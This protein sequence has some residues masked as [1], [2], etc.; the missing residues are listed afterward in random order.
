MTIE[1]R[2]DLE[3]GKYT[4]VLRSDGAM[5]ALRHDEPWRDLVGD[6]LVMAMAHEIMELRQVV[7]ADGSVLQRADA[8]GAVWE[9]LQ[10]SGA[11][12]P[13][14]QRDT[15][16]ETALVAIRALIEAA[17][18][19]TVTRA[20][21]HAYCE[22]F[23]KIWL[24]GALRERQG[25]HRAV[26]AGLEAALAAT[27]KQQDGC[28]ESNCRR[29]LTH[30]DHRG[31]IGST[32]KQQVGETGCGAC[33]DGCLGRSA[34]RVAEESPPVQV[35]EMQ[36]RLDISAVMDRCIRELRAFIDVADDYDLD[37][38]AV[39][40]LETAIESMELRKQAAFA[41]RQPGAQEQGGFRSPNEMADAL[42]RIAGG[43]LSDYEGCE[44]DELHILRCAKL[45][46]N[47]AARQP[48][49]QEPEAWQQRTRFCN[50]NG[51]WSEWAPFDHRHGFPKRVGKNEQPHDAEYRPLFLGPPAQGI[52][53]GQ[54]RKLAQGWID[55]AK[56]GAPM[57]TDESRDL[58]LSVYD[59]CGNELL[60]LIDSPQDAGPTALQRVE[61]AIKCF[62]AA[63]SEGWLDALHDGDADRIRE[64]WAR[65]VSFV[66]PALRGEIGP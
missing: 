53:L 37:E 43:A 17:A 25:I 9:L 21:V 15:G 33:G 57:G 13:G 40:A 20:M 47:L 1:T 4:V 14:T 26:R 60:A 34:C 31:G 62:E 19:P 64:L 41:A 36:A 38:M 27:G 30:P 28:T 46:R 55:H 61:Y 52:D 58:V 12:N 7:P 32:G 16:K 48:G 44:A 24:T 63:E 22:A 2:I 45:I 29:C 6:K 35:G 56:R 11:V 42:E 8:W 3:D 5:H 39:Q 59:D 23:D 65:R 10:A 54:F 66:L 51:E 49:A 50:S 18:I